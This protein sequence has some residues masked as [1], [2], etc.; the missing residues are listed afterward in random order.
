[1]WVCPKTALSFTVVVCVTLGKSCNCSV[2]QFP[3]YLVGVDGVL[4]DLKALQDSWAEQGKA[5]HHVAFPMSPCSPAETD[6]QA[7]LNLSFS[8]RTS[9]NLSKTP[10][11][12]LG[13]CF[14]PSPEML[15]SPVRKH[16][17]KSTGKSG[18]S[19]VQL[20]RGAGESR[21]GKSMWVIRCIP[22]SPCH[23]HFCGLF[24]HPKSCLAGNLPKKGFAH[25]R[26]SQ[27]GTS[28]RNNGLSFP[29]KK[30]YTSFVR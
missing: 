24:S 2:P 21:D 27:S 22:K 8:S 29:S 13:E 18:F 12:I 11:Y 19:T 20:G 17:G 16:S 4:Q 6:R 7:D 1:M 30:Y 3:N 10:R 28:D 9:T 26:P 14:S 5:M 23:R 15:R 25:P